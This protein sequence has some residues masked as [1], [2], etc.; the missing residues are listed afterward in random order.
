MISWT[1]LCSAWPDVAV[2]QFDD[3]R[4]RHRRRHRLRRGFHRGRPR[5]PRGRRCR[6]RHH[7]HGLRRHDQHRHHRRAVTFSGMG[8]PSWTPACMH[9][10][11]AKSVACPSV[12]ILAQAILSQAIF[13]Q[14]R[15]IRTSLLT[16]FVFLRRYK[17]PDSVS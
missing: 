6:R 2:R 8:A 15:H 5:R 13:S 3:R 7:E 16:S 17:W 14:E 4:R 10:C 9:H 12:A 1:A 11:T